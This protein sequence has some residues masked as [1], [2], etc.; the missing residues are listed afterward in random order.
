MGL[1]ST[2]P[3]P[4]LWKWCRQKMLCLA[5]VREGQ[6][7]QLEAEPAV[8]ASLEAVAEEQAAAEGAARQARVSFRASETP[9]RSI[10]LSLPDTCK[11]N[12]PHSWA[13]VRS[14]WLGGLAERHT[15]F[16]FSSLLNQ[17]Q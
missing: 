17:W 11:P 1:A 9:H 6:D 5:G 10:A 7:G 4:S 13:L 12:I 2:S 3:A 14:S 16:P 8:V 15:L